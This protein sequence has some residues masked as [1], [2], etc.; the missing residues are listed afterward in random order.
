MR[1]E[2][3]KKINKNNKK[4]NKKK[5]KKTTAY[6]SFLGQMMI[7]DEI[8]YQSSYATHTTEWI[9]FVIL[10]AISVGAPYFYHLNL[11]SESEKTK[12]N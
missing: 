3:K 8:E 5:K 12:T 9:I 11:G 10:S 2:R 1:K 4:K 6:T 7:L